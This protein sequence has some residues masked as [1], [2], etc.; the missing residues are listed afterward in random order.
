MSKERGYFSF[1]DRS[2]FSRPSTLHAR[3]QT[4]TAIF[5]SRVEN[6]P[7]P[8]F[9]AEMKPWNGSNEEGTGKNGGAGGAGHPDTC[10]RW[11][12]RH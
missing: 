7:A 6:F 8:T 3:S 11:G 1:E 4:P 2:V 12:C 5:G 9:G 10:P